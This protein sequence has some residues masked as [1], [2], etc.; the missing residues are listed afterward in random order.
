MIIAFK[1]FLISWLVTNHQFIVNIIDKLFEDITP[2]ESIAQSVYDIL[3]CHKCL[4][5][6]LILILT[7]NIWLAI[8]F[9]IIA[10]IIEK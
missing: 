5:F 6:T 3:T 7:Y 8:I 1:I 10:K 4:S 9:S 2:D